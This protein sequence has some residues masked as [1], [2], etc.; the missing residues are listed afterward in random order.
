M[1]TLAAVL[2]LGLLVAAAP[3]WPLRARGPP[4]AGPTGCRSTGTSSTRPGFTHFQY[5]N[6]EAPKGG[7]VKLAAIG[8]FDTLNPFILKGVPAAGIAMHVRHPHGRL[9]RRAVLRVRPGGRDDRDPG[10]PLVGR[11]HPPA[12]RRASTT[13]A[14]SPSR[15]SCGR[16]RRSRRRG[17]PSTG[18]YYAQVARA[19][20]VGARTVR[21]A[22][23]PGDNR[24]LP[25]I[26]GQLPVLSRRTGASADFEK[27]TLEPPLGSGPY[28]VESLE[29]GRSITYRRVKDYWGGEAAG[30]RGPRQLRR[31]PLRLLPR[32][33]GGARGV[34][35]RGLRLP[36]GERRPRT[37]RPRTTCRR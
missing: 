26:V 18:S 34:Q 33:H 19:E 14:P 16:S 13:A 5:V 6:P 24:E 1:R 9:G 30:E 28:R 27:T 31:D 20:K 3:A 12:H 4:Q 35:G 25:L 8:T 36:P 10:R 29:P 22:F 7:D 32:L 17:A 11:L 15:T 21:F 23:G 37:G 2:A